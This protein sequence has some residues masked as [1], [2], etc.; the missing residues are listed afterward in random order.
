M[1][2]ILTLITLCFLLVCV[3]IA[4]D[5]ASG[6]GTEDA[7][8]S[9]DIYD[10]DGNET[11]NLKKRWL[12]GEGKMPAV[13]FPHSFHQEKNEYQCIRCHDSYDGGLFKPEGVIAG[14]TYKNAAHNFC[15]TCHESKGVVRVAH[16]CYR[17][18]VGPE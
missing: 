4:A 17:C 8:R 12:D 10:K 1:K 11:F 13:M 3:G 15:W 14:T 7:D 18:H 6:T 2:K 16:T 5:N 9:G